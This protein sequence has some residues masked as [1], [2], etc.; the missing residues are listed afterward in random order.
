MQRLNRLPQRSAGAK[1]LALAIG[2]FDGMHVGH[3]A[4]LHAA[5]R[6]ARRE[7]WLSAALSFNGPP[8]AVLG[9]P[10]PPRLGH[11]DDDAAQMQGLG[12]GLL[13]HVPF[14]QALGRLSAQ[15][16]IDRVLKRRLR[17]AAVVVGHGF[18]FGRGAKG[19][20]A[21]LRRS[22]LEVVELPPLQRGGHLVSSTRLRHAVQSGHLGEAAKLL[23]R[24]WRLRA[25][26]VKGRGLGS[27]IGFPT[28]NL[29][30]PQAVLPPQGVWAGRCRV[31]S[32]K[33]PGPWKAFAA[34]I[35]VR[36]T[37]ENAG[38]LSVE[39]HL[40][41]FHGRLNGK[42]LEAEF[43]RHLRRERKFPSLKALVAQIGRDVAKAK[44]TMQYKLA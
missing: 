43:Q 12:L 42:T 21:L 14:T 24:P 35:G 27:Q 29:E 40:P 25:V 13:L 23:G 3:Q 6:L 2:V 26:V 39:L 44:K 38:K 34:N 15:D 17:C 22:R 9:Q 16:F 8:E 11:P 37:V 19:D 1:P 7:G 36:P 30:G 20:V 31:L 41:G 18:R 32:A 4:V 5:A 28:A 10:V 33:G